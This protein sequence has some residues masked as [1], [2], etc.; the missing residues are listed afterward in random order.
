MPS[1]KGELDYLKQLA[2]AGQEGIAAAR[3]EF[4]GPV[5]EISPAEAIWKPA[6]GAGIGILSAA[7]VGNR[8]D[9]S[10]VVFGG[11]LGSVLGSAVV[12]AWSSRRFAR[13]ATDK[14]IRSVNTVR[15]QHWLSSH[16]IDYA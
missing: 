4:K 10:H 1:F 14:A 5:F 11:L 13:H 15:D 6:V 7:F 2:G 12:L 3:R 9:R 8:K 16:P